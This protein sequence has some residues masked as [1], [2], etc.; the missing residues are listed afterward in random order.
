MRGR[1][2]KQV[3]ITLIAEDWDRLVELARVSERDPYQQA[4]WLLLRALDVPARPTEHQ[5]ADPDPVTAEVA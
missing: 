5:D 4:R 2:R 1:P 3:V